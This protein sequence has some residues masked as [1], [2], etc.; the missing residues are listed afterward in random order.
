[1]MHPGT[2]PGSTGRLQ[3]HRSTPRA[4]APFAM[5]RLETRELMS[6]GIIHP[7]VM[8][9]SGHRTYSALHMPA[10]TQAT[11][12][13]TVVQSA[14]SAELVTDGGFETPVATSYATFAGG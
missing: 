1:M 4:R 7:A 5:E 10:A 12:L 14:V 11:A 3:S 8:T 13:A 2:H 9:R 6:A